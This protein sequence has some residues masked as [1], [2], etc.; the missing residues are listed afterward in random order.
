MAMIQA[1]GVPA[2]VVEDA[3]NQGEDPQLKHHEFF[4]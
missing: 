4:K 3:Q 1:V 2:G